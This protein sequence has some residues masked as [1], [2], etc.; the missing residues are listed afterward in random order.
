MLKIYMCI[1]YVEIFNLIN[2]N[3]YKTYIKYS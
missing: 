1:F 3:I 2:Y